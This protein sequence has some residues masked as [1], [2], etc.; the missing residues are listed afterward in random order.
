M[1]QKRRQD[2]VK[3]EQEAVAAKRQKLAERAAKAAAEAEKIARV[4]LVLDTT[5]LKQMTKP[6]LALQLEK[7]RSLGDKT[8]PMKS[9]LR[10][11]PQLLDALLAA[12]E[13][14]EIATA[15]RETEPDDALKPESEVLTSSMDY[16]LDSDT[17]D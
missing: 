13:R 3:A 15:D 2:L 7:L 10:N 8:I 12:V 4:D 9:H 5:A 14:Y 17:E 16:G 6:Q 11:K 1:E